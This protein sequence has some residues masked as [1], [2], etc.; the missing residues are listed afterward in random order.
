[1]IIRPAFFRRPA[2][3]AGLALAAVAFFIMQSVRAVEPPAG[4]S[5][6]KANALAPGL[7]IPAGTKPLIDYWMR[8]TYVTLGPDSFYYL[9]GTTADPHRAFDAKG[10][11]CWDWNDGVYL[12]RSKDLQHWE[13]LGCVWSLDKDATWEGRFSHK[14]AT[15]HITGFMLDAKR[16]AVWAPELHYVRSATNWFLVACMNDDAP[17]KGSFILRSKTGKPEGPY[18]NIPGNLAGPIFE[19]IDGSLFEDDDGSVWFIGHNH[20]Y[21]RMKPDFSG[22]AGELKQFKETAY[23]PE[24]Y[25]EGAYIFKSGGKYH[26]LQAAWSFRLADGTFT[27]DAQ[28]EKAGAVRWS[29][30]CLLADA[31]R[32]EGPYGPRYTLGVGL[33]HNNVFQDA[34]GN[35][36]AT[37][38]GNP[39]GSTEFKQPF[40]CRPGIVRL[41]FA[42]GMFSPAPDSERLQSAHNSAFK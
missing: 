16:R 24:P 25:L 36:W 17:Q 10:P 34:S 22:F 18:E 21:A 39:R 37:L 40:Y 29:Y 31:D 12:W 8:D 15:R 7:Q 28:K 20:F 2:V 3:A 26:L 5:Y 41:Q 4:E 6:G 30:D 14:K 33:G 38:F 35:W 11:H 27:Y 9:T 32:L 23:S 19:N 13:S 42:Q 1:M